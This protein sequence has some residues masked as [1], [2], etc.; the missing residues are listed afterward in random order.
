MKT[1]LSFSEQRKMTLLLND[2]TA[3]APAVGHPCPVCHRVFVQTT[4]RGVPCDSC[5]DDILEEERYELRKAEDEAE[6]AERDYNYSV[7]GHGGTWGG[8]D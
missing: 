4:I 7:Y 1:A 5:Q 3:T 6:E 2:W 8:R